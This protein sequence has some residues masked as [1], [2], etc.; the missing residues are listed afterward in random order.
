MASGA[1]AALQ[2]A[3]RIGDQRSQRGTY[4]RLV[5]L[6]NQ[7]GD[8]AGAKQVLASLK[9][10]D[11]EMLSG[12]SGATRGDAFRGLAKAQVMAGDIPGALIWARHE[13]S[14]YRKA[15]ALMG[16]ALG[17]LEQQGIRELDHDIPRFRH[18]LVKGRIDKLAIACEP[19]RRPI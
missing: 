11:D 3:G 2:T 16:A 10:T 14:L 19:F 1:T 13:S 17:M 8:V 12:G 5:F 6:L 15:E 7:K 18:L 4:L 9:V